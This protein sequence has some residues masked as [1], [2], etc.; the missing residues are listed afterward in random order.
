MKAEKPQNN[1]TKRVDA[2]LGYL[3]AEKRYSFLTTAAYRNDLTYFIDYVEQTFDE[4]EWEAVDRKILRSYVAHLAGE[5]NMKPYSVRRKVS[6]LRSFFRYEIK[7]GR[8][9]ENPTTKLPLPKAG[10][11]LVYFVEET[12]MQQLDRAEAATVQERIEGNSVAAA[13]AD[14]ANRVV[15]AAQTSKLSKLRG[16]KTG[17]KPKQKSPFETYRDYL[18]LTMFY[19]TG[20]RLAELLSLKDRKVDTRQAVL[21]VLGKRNKERQIPLHAM[22]CEDIEIYRKMRADEVGVPKSD[23]FFVNLQG[24]PMS[25]SAVYRLVHTC[26]RKYTTIDKC[27]PHVLRHTFATHLLN[28][29]ADLDAVKTLLGHSSLA[30]TQV[31]TH[32]TIEKLKKAYVMA[33]PKA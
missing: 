10:K 5:R 28:E 31:Y 13:T 27:S 7:A 3:Q 16:H 1:M 19:A 25:R 30:S 9:K 33:H 18:V 20:I 8:L 6:A 17:R 21:T 2:F 22:L 23:C 12:G 14:A 32:N 29:G 4:K 11:R 15:T 26:L 24:V